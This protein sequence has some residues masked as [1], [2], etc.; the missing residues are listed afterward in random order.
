M[1]AAVHRRQINPGKSFMPKR[2][3]LILLALLGL[4]ALYAAGLG[5]RHIVLQ[6]QYAAY[7]RDLPFQ[8]ES[9]LEFRYVRLLAESGRLPEVDTKIQIPEGVRV[10]ET[11]GIGAEYVYAR[12]ARGL[13]AAWSLTDR[14]RWVSVAWFCLSIPLLSLW[15][16]WWLKSAWAAGLGGAYY[17][18]SLASVMRSTGQELSHENFALPLLIGHLAFG[19]LADAQSRGRAFAAAALAAAVLLGCALAAWDL[20]QYYVLLWAVLSYLRVAGGAWFQDSRRRVAW[21][22][23]LTALVITG[24]VN[25]YLRTHAFVASYAM[26]L[27]YGT[28]LVILLSGIGASAPA[29]VGGGWLRRALAGRWGRICLPLAPVIVGALLLSAYGETYGHF[30]ELLWAKLRFLNQK[31]ADPALL[32]FNQRILWTPALNS[33][34]LALTE[35]MFPAILPLFAVAVVIIIFQPRWRSDPKLKELLF[36]GA[37]SLPVF[38]LFMRFHV[39]VAIFAAAVLGWLGGW[40]VARKSV[41]HAL[42]LVL[43]LAGVGVEAGQVLSN[44]VRWGSVPVYLAQRRELAQWLR[45]N[46]PAE[47]VLANFG[48][49]AFLLAY[50]EMPIV[51]HPKFESPENRRRIQAYGAALFLGNEAGFREWADRRGAA[52]YV[53]SLGEFA[54]QYPDQ[55]MR[56][57]VN[58]LQP[59]ATAAARVLE[60]QPDRARYFQRLWE[61]GKFRVFRIVTRADE[62]TARRCV[63]RAQ[64]A[65]RA[66]RR[67]EAE[68]QAG[69]ALMYDPQAVGAAQVLLQARRG[70]K[71]RGRINSE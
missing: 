39:F 51:L 14:V 46:A 37:V 57:F 17:A 25:P 67:A 36:Y 28:G 1:N 70:D 49:S 38:F 22:L 71:A 7:G 64:A 40:A 32:T 4:A 18:V 66:G 62:E 20:I 8:L 29:P 65:L 19:A 3:I 52:L 33:V 54:G 16:W 42:V 68:G 24:M 31:P 26:L 47:P 34:N 11:Y 56:Y 35:I 21:G 5:I 53:H 30:L 43:L 23:N 45:E 41:G 69:R 48:L 2:L 59:P 63:A 9:A 60:Q 10:R 15:L 12:L 27:A 44:P 61:N 55:Q 6:A 58:A 50:G 13:P